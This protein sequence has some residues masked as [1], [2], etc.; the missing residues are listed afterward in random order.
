MRSLTSTAS[1]TAFTIILTKLR[2]LTKIFCEVL[3]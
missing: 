1:N 3:G 2:T